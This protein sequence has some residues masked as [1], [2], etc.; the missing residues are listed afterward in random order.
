LAAGE[1]CWQGKDE[2]GDGTTR[3]SGDRGGG[4]ANAESRDKSGAAS[5]AE[6]RTMNRRRLNGAGAAIFRS[7]PSMIFLGNGP[8]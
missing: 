4:E 2:A 3:R 8:S 5:T 7:F 1:A 6:P